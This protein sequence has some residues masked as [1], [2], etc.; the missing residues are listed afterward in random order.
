MQIDIPPIFINRTQTQHISFVNTE[1]LSTCSCTPHNHPPCS[2]YSACTHV[3][4]EVYSSV[5]VSLLML[6]SPRSIAAGS[7]EWHHSWWDTSPGLWPMCTRAK[8]HQVCVWQWRSEREVLSRPGTVCVCHTEVPKDR[9]CQV[10]P[11]IHIQIWRGTDTLKHILCWWDN[12]CSEPNYIV[13]RIEVMWC[14]YLCVVCNIYHDIFGATQL[15][16]P[17]MQYPMTSFARFTFSQKIKSPW[18]HQ[19]VLTSPG[20]LTFN[21]L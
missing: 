15:S 21:H 9:A 2:I 8:G 18:L 1:W 4:I 3:T 6:M 7:Q 11:H 17:L 12:L 20:L 5:G 10:H 19:P 14:T 13:T 16:P